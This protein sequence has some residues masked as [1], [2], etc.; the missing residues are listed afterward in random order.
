MSIF[1]KHLQ[2]FVSFTIIYFAATYCT[3]LY[4]AVDAEIAQ[5]VEHFTRNEGVEGSSPFFSFVRMQS[6]INIID[7]RLFFCSVKR[8]VAGTKSVPIYIN[9]KVPGY[10]LVGVFFLDKMNQAIQQDGDQT[11]NHDAHQYHVQFKYLGTIDN[12]V[13]EAA[14]CSQKFADDHAY[15]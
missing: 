9:I 14:S 13:T 1:K 6:R 8:Y 10:S 3:L 4:V 12:Q 5:L 15:Q 2:I 7:F 11:E